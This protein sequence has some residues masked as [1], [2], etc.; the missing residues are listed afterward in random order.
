M[1]VQNIDYDIVGSYNNERITSIDA[2]RSVNMFEYLDP[3]GKKGKALLSTSGLTNTNL[4]FGTEHGG[5]RAQYL[6]N[7]FTYCI[8]GSTVF[9]IN[10]IN[11]AVAILGS[12]ATSSGYAAIEANNAA[13]P[14]VIFVDG[15]NGYIWDTIA[16]TFTQITDTSFPSNPIDV[17]FLDGFFVVANGGTNTF[18]LSQ[19][20]QGLVWGVASNLYTADSGTNLFTIAGTTA[21][22]QTGV[23]V[24]FT[25]GMGGTIPTTTPQ[26]NITDTFYVIRVSNTTFHIATSLANAYANVF[27]TINMD[28]TPPNTI[29]SLGQLQQGAITSHPGNIVGCRCLHRKLFLFSVFYTEVWENAGIG[30]NLPFRRNNDLLIEYGTPCIGSISVGFDILMFLSE[31]RDGLGSVMLVPGTGAQPVSTRALDFQLAQ[32]A[33][34]PLQG[35]S[36]ARAFLIKENGLIFYR[37]NF[38]RANHTYVWGASMSTGQDADGIQKWH[39]EEV[40]NHDRH[41]AQTHSFMNGINYVGHYALPILYSVSPLVSTNDGEPIRRMR[42]AKPFVV[43]SYQRIRIDRFQLDLLQG[44]VSNLINQN[45]ELD[46]LTENNFLITTEDDIDILLEQVIPNPLPEYPQVFLAVS[47]DSGQTFGYEVVAPMGAVGQR[48]FRT[49]WRKL[50]T[51][52]RGQAFVPRIQFFDEVPFIILGASWVFEVMPE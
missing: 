20:N 27:V 32:Y 12:I 9:S 50:G 48:T 46:L 21:N 37:L 31:S 25:V 44:S 8:V 43:P 34:N 40:L 6:F 24:T 42:I 29:T 2:E 52:P 33:A 17:T 45:I 16:M 49:V 28:G 38:T 7:G 51:I 22:Y 11:L 36:D 1:A 30:S 13:H 10:A 47:R 18:Q 26:I 14:Q 15:L 3:L 39:E 19:L 35:V 41:P 4:V 5:F 23:A